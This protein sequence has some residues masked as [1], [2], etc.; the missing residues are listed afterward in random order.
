MV[1]HGRRKE[2]AP[3]RVIRGGS[4]YHYSS[5]HAF[6]GPRLEPPRPPTRRPRFSSL[7]GRSVTLCA[8]VFTLWEGGGVAAQP[9]LGVAPRDRRHA[10]GPVG[11]PRVIVWLIPQ[12]EKFSQA[13]RFTREADWKARCWRCR[14]CSSDAAY[15]RSKQGAPTRVSQLLARLTA[16]GGAPTIARSPAGPFEHGCRHRDRRRAGA[17]GAGS[18]DFGSRAR[19]EARRESDSTSRSFS[20]LL[21][22]RNC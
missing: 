1:G 14:N 19:G 21:R 10:P 16:S 9:S 2:S 18:V 15:S 7:T 11:I 3:V 17:R 6:G 22:H 4:W 20:A 13:R 12:L 5:G 8:L